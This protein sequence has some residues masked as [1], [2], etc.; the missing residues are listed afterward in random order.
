MHPPPGVDKLIDTHIL[1]GAIR[2]LAIPFVLNLCDLPCSL[3]VE[4]VDPAGYGLLFA[5]ALYDVAGTQVH[6]DGIATGCHFVV[7]TLNL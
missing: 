6:S 2:E 4:D 5:N 3:V 7:E 1:E